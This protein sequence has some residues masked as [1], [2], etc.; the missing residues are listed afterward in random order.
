MP[1]KKSA[2]VTKTMQ[3]GLGEAIQRLFR[4]ESKLKNGH[5]TVPDQDR[6]ERRMILDAL[7]TH[8]LDLGF[9][10]NSDGVPDTIEI[11]ARSAETACC[12][13]VSSD[14]SRSAKTTSS[15]RTTTTSRRAAKG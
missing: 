9:D 4:L 13:I 11:F 2:S 10:C 7:N 14:T 8:K 12:K 6:D 15:R 3:M 1:A 5:T